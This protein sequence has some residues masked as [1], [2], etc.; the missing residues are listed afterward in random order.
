MTSNILNKLP[1]IAI[2]SSFSVFLYNTPL[3]AEG[4]LAKALPELDSSFSQSLNLSAAL[5]YDTNP[6]LS[7]QEEAVW[8]NRLQPHYK[9][10]HNS[11]QNEQYFDMGVTLQR[12][13]DPDISV[14]RQDPKITLGF[15]HLFSRGAI[16]ANVGYLRRSTRISELSET[17]LVIDDGSMFNRFLN[18]TAT[19][20]PNDL[21]TS[22]TLLSYSTTTYSGAN[23]L[24]AFDNLSINSSLNFELNEVLTTKFNIG[25]TEITRS[26]GKSYLVNPMA[27]FNWLAKPNLELE[28]LLGLNRVMVQSLPDDTGFSATTNLSYKAEFNS[29]NASYIRS[30]RP[31]GLGFQESDRVNLVWKHTLNESTYFG[32]NLQNNKNKNINEIETQISTINFNKKINQEWGLNLYY[33][34]KKIQRQVQDAS[35]NIL[36]FVINYGY[37]DYQDEY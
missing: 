21:T 6:L 27:G 34:N 15:S 8:I 19:Y 24:R 9:I 26:T 35:A 16:G 5:I 37:T 30:V 12:S 29:Y 36:G 7:Q 20:Q 3:K 31:T 14:N 23:Q 17:G 22:N 4:Q 13:S 10:Q 28:M 11:E 2:V 32:I 33:K 1:Q 25:L 18:L